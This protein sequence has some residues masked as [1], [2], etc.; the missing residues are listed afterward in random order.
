MKRFY[1]EVSTAPAEGGFA[2]L[3]DGKPVKTPGRNRLIL[4]T[5]VLAEAVAQ[6]WREQ[7]QEILAATMPL[8]RLVN[9]VIDGVMVN[10]ADVMKAILHF[11]EDDLVCY[12]A[13][14]PPELLARQRQG[15]D[16]WLDWVR[17]RHGV[18]LT[19]AHGLNP[20]D[21]SLDALLALRQA[22]EE[23]DDFCLG[24]LHVIVSITGS[25]VL[26]LA[27]AEGAL[28]GG[29]AFQLSRIDE[30]YQAEKWGEDDQA[31][32][33]SHALGRELDDAVV[34]IALIHAKGF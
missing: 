11:G 2:V 28:K 30:I 10:R 20:V 6:E 17:Q 4:P 5:L 34:L 21:Q 29:E 31:V 22:I 12:R 9:T 26:G 1:K 7:D 33:R 16:R 24:A 23:F 15:W 19:V 27:V 18:H 25:L 3:L 14:Q 13:H 32:K 8:L